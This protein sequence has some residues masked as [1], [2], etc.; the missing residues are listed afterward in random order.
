MFKNGLKT[1]TPLAGL[2]GSFNLLGSMPGGPTGLMIGAVFAE[3]ARMVTRRSFVSSTGAAMAP[4][5][6]LVPVLA[7]R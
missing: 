1:F 6:A 5:L 3:R 2:A 4:H 7:T